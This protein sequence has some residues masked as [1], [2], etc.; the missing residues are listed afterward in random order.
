MKSVSGK[1]MAKLA[2]IHGWK[3]ARINGSHPIYTQDGRIER[4][5]IP[6]HG[7]KVLKEGLQRSLIKVIP[8]ND[9]DL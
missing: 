6:V 7:N 5:V 1:R 9:T 2:V 8:V 4:L 3:L